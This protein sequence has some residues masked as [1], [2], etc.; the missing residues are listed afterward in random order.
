MWQHII[1]VVCVLFTVLSATLDVNV[2]R[3]DMFDS[4]HFVEPYSR[5]C[6]QQI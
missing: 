5:I 4:A 3:F 6:L 2:V 1:R